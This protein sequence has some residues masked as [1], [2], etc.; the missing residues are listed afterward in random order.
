MCVITRARMPSFFLQDFNLVA[1]PETGAPWLLPQ[2]IMP[3]EPEP[4]NTKGISE[5]LDE[6]GAEEEEEER[7]IAA[8]AAGEEVVEDEAKL[9][10]ASSSSAQELTTTTPASTTTATA[11]SP[12]LNES[13]TPQG[14]SVYVL[15][16]QD[17]L[18][19]FGLKGSPF[20]KSPIRLAGA[21][22]AKR[23]IMGKVVWRQD[24]DRY[25]VNAMRQNIVDGLLYLNKLCATMG[26]HYLVRCWG[27]DDVK[28]KHSG[29]IL[30]FRP[31]SLSG[32]GEE[33]SANANP[34]AAEP[35]P[36]ATFDVQK[37][38]IQGEIATTTLAVYNMD[39][40]LG[41]EYMKQFR[42]NATAMSEGNIFMLA[43]RRTVD[44]Q[45]KLWKLQGYLDKYP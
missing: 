16:R 42:D 26:R 19:G 9:E 4:P 11:T 3:D 33:S 39:L 31:S 44:L 37:T 24:M 25:I 5:A 38:D 6:A 12:N 36:F 14:R 45:A 22:P 15:A 2:S 18:S 1:N 30:W 27:W 17:L 23:H 34:D 40:L 20:E 21:D 28:Y 41:P 7:A 10:L 8:A 32:E 43:G 35:G 13:Q 29:S